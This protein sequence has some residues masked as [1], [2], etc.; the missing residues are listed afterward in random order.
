[1]RHIGSLLVALLLAPLALPL[2]GRGL[3]GLAEAAGSA[4]ETGATDQL[5][6]VA[7]ASAVGLAGLIIAVLTLARLSPLGPTLA[8]LG[9]L[10]VGVWALQDPAGFLAQVRPDRI[11]LTDA[12]V[13]MAAQLGL[14]LAVPL[15][16]SCFLPHR[17]R[18]QRP[19]Q[20]GAE[21]ALRAEPP[22]LTDAT[23]RTLDDLPPVVVQPAE[24]R[25]GTPEEEETTVSLRPTGTRAFRRSR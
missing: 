15:L 4:E 14:L 12:Q 9:Y 3:V 5:G 22:T 24:P 6:I 25:P 10:A 23:T 13:T 8:G 18:R 19:G 7:S 17:W 2:A 16:L 11:G 1:M 21:A 20:A